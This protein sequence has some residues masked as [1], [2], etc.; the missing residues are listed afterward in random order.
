MTKLRKA[1]YVSIVVVMGILFLLLTVLKQ[2]GILSRYLEGILIMICINIILATSLNITVGC[3]GQINLGHAGFMSV[4][5]YAAALFTKSA[6][7]EGI[8]IGR[9]HV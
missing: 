7:V 1:S 8:Q 2:T 6:L 3:M 5:A 4:G 9:A